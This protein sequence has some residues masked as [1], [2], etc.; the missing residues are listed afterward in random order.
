[1]HVTVFLD[2]VG[3]NPDDVIRGDNRKQSVV[4]RQ[5]DTPCVLFPVRQGW[6]IQR[7]RQNKIFLFFFFFFP[8][9]SPW[10]EDAYASITYQNLWSLPGAAPAKFSAKRNAI[11]K[12]KRPQIKECQSLRKWRD[13]GR[14]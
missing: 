12:K 10:F 9:F 1:M 13:A 6:V 3:E 14:L 4:G 11:N 2:S 5:Q 8:A 7:S